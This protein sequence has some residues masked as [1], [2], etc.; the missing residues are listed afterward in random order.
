MD[1]IY[2]LQN[3]DKLFLTKQNEWS[4]GRD[5]GSLFKTRH[6][7]EAL[8]HLVE[9][10]AKDFRQ[11]IHIL[12]CPPKSN[13]FPDIAAEDLPPPFPK[14]AA[15]Q[16]ST[17]LEL[18]ELGSTAPSEAEQEAAADAEEAPALAD[19]DAPESGLDGAEADAGADEDT[20]SESEADE[21]LTGEHS[22]PYRVHEI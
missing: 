12:E 14:V 22:H 3:Q 5:L 1:H 17:E 2:L 15:E 16:E 6:R 4:D 20:K 21:P 11:R 7:D 9:V 19:D 8:N 10:N 18:P 13:G